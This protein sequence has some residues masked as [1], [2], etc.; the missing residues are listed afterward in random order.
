MF[1]E[2]H[3]GGEKSLLIHIEKFLHSEQEDI[4]EFSELAQASGVEILDLLS[5]KGDQPNPRFFISSGKVKDITNRVQ[6]LCVELV[7]VN[8]ILSPTQE[9]NLEREFKCRVLDR[10]GLILDIFAQRVRTHEGKLQVELAQLE[11]MSTRLIRGWTH[12]ERQKGGVGLRGPGETQLETDRRLL[13]IRIKSIHAR[14]DKVRSQRE[15]T[16]R[17]RTKA[18]MPQIS[19][20]GYTNA[21]KSTLFNRVTDSNVYVEDQLFA[22]LDPTLRR[23]DL[24]HAGPAI[25][26]DTVGFIRHLPHRLI[27]AFRATLEESV[28]ATLLIHVVD[29]SNEEKM[30]HI[31]QV[32]LVLQEIEADHIPQL[33]VYNKIDKISGIEPRID[34]DAAGVPQ[35]VWLSS[36]NQEAIPL[37]FEA[38]SE[39][40]AQSLSYYSLKLKPEQG[41]LRSKF[42]E[43][44]VV[45]QESYLEDGQIQLDIALP[46]TMYDKVMMNDAYHIS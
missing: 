41:R 26:V 9:R 23:I 12:L 30:E 2:R 18:E 27:N 1:F 42:Y 13:K 8:G 10:V 15:Q 19:I 5:V 14:L 17:A 7:L 44:G 45:I 38:L 11:Y 28:N 43:L 3:A 25:L 46:K 35:A 32:S 39:R 4:H 40:I 37:L 22:T 21:G 16:R 6:L 33:L 29:A 20:V 24:P 34:R 31:D 36:L